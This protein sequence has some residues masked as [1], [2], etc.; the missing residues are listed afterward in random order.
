MCPRL[1]N[2][3]LDRDL[4][5]ALEAVTRVAPRVAV[6]GFSLG[7]NLALPALGRSPSRLP[8]G[9]LGVGAVSPPLDLAACVA[10]LE[11][12]VNRL[13]QAYFLRNLRLPSPYRPRLC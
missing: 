10:A 11:R 8:P 5:A 6:V 7:A 12:P 9:L 3:G 2:A 13:Y 4:V 1:Y